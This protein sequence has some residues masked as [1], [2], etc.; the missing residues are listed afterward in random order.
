MVS[1]GYLLEIQ[2]PKRFN[3]ERAGF[4]TSTRVPVLIRDP[5]NAGKREVEYARTFVND[6]FEALFSADG[7]NKQGKHYTD[8]IDMDSFVNMY[9]L[10][11]L[12][13]NVDAGQTSFYMV[14]D[15]GKLLFSPLWDMDNAFSHEFQR[16]EKSL[17]DPTIWW[18]NSMSNPHPTVLTAA[19]KQEDFREAVRLRWNQLLKENVFENTAEKIRQIFEEQEASVQMNMI[20]FKKKDPSEV[21]Q[22]LIEEYDR[23]QQFVQD[24]VEV[25]TKG[26]SGQSAMLYYNANGGSGYVYNRQIACQGETVILSDDV[27][28]PN[29]ILPPDEALHF[30]GWNTAP[31][32]SGESYQAGEELVLNA[33]ET[34]LYAMWQ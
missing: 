26:F 28:E 10:Q 31:D 15:N 23:M 24:R 2:L 16:F 11:E 18:A 33:P 4:V 12:S 13:M 6:A 27:Q 3:K 5:E 8:Y 21:H 19:Y 14:L 29:K 20:R 17:E 7:R 30:A 25:L 22:Y 9:I 34:V 1:G 32:G